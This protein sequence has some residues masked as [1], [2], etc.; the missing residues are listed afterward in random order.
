[1][2]LRTPSEAAYGNERPPTRVWLSV[3]IVTYSLT[4]LGQA[5]LSTPDSAS[6]LR[7]DVSL[8]PV[9]VVVRDHQ[10]HPVGNLGKD[11]FQVFDQGK[12][13][14]IQQFSAERSGG[15]ISNV[16]GTAGSPVPPETRFTVYLFDDLHLQRE[17]LARAREAADRQIAHLSSFPSERA[18]LYTT[19]GRNRADFDAGPEKLRAALAHLEPQGKPSASDCPTMTYYIADLIEEKGDREALS[20]ATDEVLSCAFGGNRRHRPEA[21]QMASAVARE[22]TAIGKAET[23]NSLG[24]LKR[25]IQ[26]MSLAPGRKLIVLVSPGFFV[27]D[28]NAQAEIMDLA[29]RAD[30]DISALDPRGLLLPAPELDRRIVT[31]LTTAEIENAAVLEALTDATGGVF[32]HNNNDVEAG[33]QRIAA[34]PEYSYTLAFSPQGLK[35]D[36]HFHKLKV[37]VNNGENFTL[38]ARKGYYAGKKKP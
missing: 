16:A 20:I 14:V 13:Q 4:A 37:T 10:G 22:K 12:L 38:Q 33:F 2:R 18:A 6:T 19:S 8:V 32:F 24:I 36:G 1:M 21:I 11:D 3:L 30:I 9:H 15:P 23:A 27:S 29:A 31:Y 17:D 25:L 28:A 34:V 35:F 5:A 26:A 7:S